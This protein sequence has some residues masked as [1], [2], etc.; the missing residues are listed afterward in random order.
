MY[1]HALYFYSAIK[2]FLDEKQVFE[3][4]KSLWHKKAMLVKLNEHSRSCNTSLQSAVDCVI[5]GYHR[6][7]KISNVVEVNIT[8]CLYT[9]LS[10]HVIFHTL[11][12]RLWYRRA[13]TCSEIFIRSQFAMIESCGLDFRS[14]F[15]AYKS[16]QLLDYQCLSTVYPKKSGSDRSNTYC[17]QFVWR[18]K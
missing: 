17:V 14:L 10:C 15:T 12:C 7:T 13:I 4:R 11:C 2:I 8:Y 16:Q 9:Q 18:D 6:V 5:N 1:V 3:C